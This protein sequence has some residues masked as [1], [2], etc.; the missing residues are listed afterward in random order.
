[1]YF[2]PDSQSENRR[3]LSVHKCARVISQSFHQKKGGRIFST[4]TKFPMNIQCF[5]TLKKTVGSSLSFY[6]PVPHRF[7]RQWK[8]CFSCFWVDI[9]N[10]I[11]DTMEPCWGLL[12]DTTGSEIELYWVI[13]YKKHTWWFKPGRKPTDPYAHLCTLMH[14]YAYLCTLIEGVHFFFEFG[15]NNFFPQG[16]NMELSCKS[17][18]KS[19]NRH[20]SEKQAPEIIWPCRLRQP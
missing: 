5:C 12:E 3:N 6:R 8:S 18:P 19:W 11:F 20:S 9:W 7:R 10:S 2:W 16:F 1:M 15:K 4:K 14:T 13:T 17:G